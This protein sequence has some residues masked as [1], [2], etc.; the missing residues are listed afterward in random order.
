MKNLLALDPGH[1]TGWAIYDKLG[2]E[3][4]LRGGGVFNPYKGFPPILLRSTTVVIE[5][6]RITPT[7]PNPEDILKV[8][9][10]VGRFEERFWDKTVILVR[11]SEWK[12]TIDGDIMCARI[13]KETSLRDRPGL[14]GYTGGYRHNMID[15]VGL[16]RWLLKQPI[17]KVEID[18]G[19]KIDDLGKHY[20][21]RSVR[22]V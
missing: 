5:N 10:I 1:H 21:G 3:W 8:A 4:V 16:G 22:R 12:G 17:A 15:A 18:V 14:L 19:T 7:T 20:R 6:P 2:E 9:R 13:E 11:P